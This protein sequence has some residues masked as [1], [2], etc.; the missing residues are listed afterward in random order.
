MSNGPKVGLGPADGPDHEEPNYRPG[1]FRARDLADCANRE[2]KQRVRVYPRLVEQ[3]KMSKEFADRQIKMMR[4]IAADY[5]TL[6]EADEAKERL[7]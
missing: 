7:F 2:V 6:A 1:D 4:K 3:G 5:E